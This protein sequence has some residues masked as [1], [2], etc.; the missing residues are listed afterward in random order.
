M[1]PN[2][3]EKERPVEKKLT[4]EVI[5]KKITEPFNKLGHVVETYYSDE[6]PRGLA[7]LDNHN[8]MTG[9]R[10]A[11]INYDSDNRETVQKSKILIAEGKSSQK[12]VVTSKL[13]VTV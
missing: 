3:A 6:S 5:V 10:E 13:S 12:S 2:S 8:K 7:D 1:T 4:T 11:T 9:I